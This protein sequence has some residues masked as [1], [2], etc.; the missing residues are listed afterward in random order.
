[1]QANVHYRNTYLLI[2][3]HARNKQVFVID[4]TIKKASWST[5]WKKEFSFIKPLLRTVE[6]QFLPGEQTKNQL[7]W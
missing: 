6:I 2:I 3:H 7:S 5:G 1:M 4:C